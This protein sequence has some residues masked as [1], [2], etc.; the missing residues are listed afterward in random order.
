MVEVRGSNGAFYKVPGARGRAGPQGRERGRRREEEAAAAPPPR[1]E[2]ER[3]PRGRR[4]EGAP[5]RAGGRGGSLAV[6][7]GSEPGPPGPSGLEARRGGEREGLGPSSF[8]GR[9]AWGRLVPALSED[10]R[11]DG[12]LMAKSSAFVAT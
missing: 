1:A 10:Q 11:W 5:S 8:V 3:R 12:A 6:A 2:G 9:G 7:A 4:E